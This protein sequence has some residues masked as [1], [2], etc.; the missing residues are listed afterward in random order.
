[1]SVDIVTDDQIVELIRM[2]KVIINPNARFVEHCGHNKKNFDVEGDPGYSFTLYIRQNLRGGMS[3][4]FSCGLL[5]HMPSGDRLTLVRYNGPNHF[6]RNILDKT[7]LAPNCHIHFAREDYIMA[8]LAPEGHA[9]ITDRYK[10]LEGALHCLV[11]DCNI[12][13][14]S[15]QSDMIQ[16]TLPF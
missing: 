6:H 2:E 7:R 14:L 4:D 12:A 10:T 16:Q 3:D 13:N 5:W 15:T 9:S 8:G 11:Q 1:M